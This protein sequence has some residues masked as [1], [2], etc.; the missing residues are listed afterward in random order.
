MTIKGDSYV[1]KSDYQARVEEKFGKPLKDI[2][3]ELC[4]Q[5]DVILTEGASI[6]D[7]P[8]SVYKSWRNKFRYGPLQLRIMQKRFIMKEWNNTIMS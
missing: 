5:K 2:M 1:N 4:V 8:K 6:L 3:Y 7:V